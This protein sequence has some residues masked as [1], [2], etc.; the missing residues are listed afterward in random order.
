MAYGGVTAEALDT[1]ESVD[2]G[3]DRLL[4]A[5]VAKVFERRPLDKNEEPYTEEQATHWLSFIAQGLYSHVETIFRLEEL[6]AKW[7]STIRDKIKY[8]LIFGLLAGLLAGLL[9]GLLGGLSEEVIGVLSEELTGVLIFWLISRLSGV[10][11]AGLSIGLIFGLSVGL[12]VGLIAGLGA[13]RI[14]VADEV[15][16]APPPRNQWWDLCKEILIS[17]LFVGLI[18]VPIFG[19][20]AGLSAG[21]REGLI[22]GL[23]FMLTGVLINMFKSKQL[24]NQRPLPNHGLFQLRKVVLIFGLMVG[25]MAGVLGWEFGGPS[26]GL[27][28]GLLYGLLVGLGE[29]LGNLIGHYTIR[30]FLAKQNLLP[31]R[32]SGWRKEDRDRELVAYL[33]S[34]ADRWLLRRVGN[35]WVFRHRYLLEYFAERSP[36]KLDKV[37]RKESRVERGGLTPYTKHM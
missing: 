3:C 32:W 35:G 13:G 7:L 30:H 37:E 33:D 28:F 18:A 19:L 8:R 16:F 12:S 14:D 36:V 21:L 34:M 29:G 26:F 5:Y 20:S 10:L 17:G 11:G 4:G 25:L 24:L 27:G 23:L 22:G 2:R 6:Q 1:A 9:V 31:F 15:V